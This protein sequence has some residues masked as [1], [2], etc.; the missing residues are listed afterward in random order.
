MDIHF[1]S[2]KTFPP[3]L[4]VSAAASPARLMRLSKAPL[5]DSAAELSPN[6]LAQ[7]GRYPDTPLVHPTVINTPRVRMTKRTGKRKRRAR[8]ALALL[9]FHW[10]LCWW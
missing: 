6:E 5:P 2:T 8:E 9:W 7:L 10:E 3:L 4:P 1:F